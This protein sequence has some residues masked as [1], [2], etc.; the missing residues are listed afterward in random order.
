MTD[1]ETSFGSWAVKY[2]W[3][4]IAVTIFCT[5]SCGAGL[6]HLTFKKDKQVFFGRQNPQLQAFKAFED[7]YTKD[8]NLVIAFAP[9]D[10]NVFSRR[11]LTMLEELT[12][13]CW[14]VPYSSRVYSITNFQNARV[15]GDDLIVEDLFQ[16][17]AGLSDEEIKRR[18]AIALSEPNL[19]NL[20]ISPSGHATGVL[21]TITKPGKSPTETS[22]IADYGRKLVND[23]RSRYPDI[24]FYLTG[25]VM[26]DVALEEATLKDLTT[27][28]PVVCFVLFLCMGVLLRSFTGTIS[29]FLV[30]CASMITAVGL[31]CWFGIEMTPSSSNAPGAILTLAV[32]DSVHILT[33]FFHEMRLGKDKQ[34]AIVEAMRINFQPVYLTSITTTIGF[35]TMNFSDSPPFRDFG[36]TVAMGVMAALVY[37]LLFL[38]ALMAVLPIRIRKEAKTENRYIDRLAEFV[39]KRREP[40]FWFFLI[41]VPIMVYGTFKIELNDDFIKYYDHSFEFRRASDFVGENIT[42]VYRIEYSLDA[43]ESQGINN[44]EYLKTVASFADWYRSQNNVVHVSAVTDIIK[45]LNKNLHD[46][47]ETY[48]RIPDKRDQVAQ[49]LFLYEISLPFGLDL[50]SQINV[51]RSATRMSVNL[52]GATSRTLIEI[53]KKAQQWLATNAPTSMQTFG[54]GTSIIFA[55]ISKRNIKSMLGASF[56][57]LL[58][59][60]VVIMAGMRAYKLIFVFLIPNIIPLIMAFGTWGFIVGRVGLAISVIAALTL[61]IIVDD[62][63][64]YVSKYLRAR[65]E[66]KKSPADAVRYSFHTVGRALFMTTA[67]LVAGFSVLT[68]SH[69]QINSDLGYMTVITLVFALALDFLLLPVLLIKADS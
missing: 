5:I 15:E 37:S 29:A 11:T 9:E 56:F 46:D 40:I 25:S 63:I 42:G 49:L 2:R 16:N 6:R 22:E 67:V 50:N 7:T 66:Y 62:T 65:R 58:F 14:K 52:K 30:I 31:A 57:A 21:V 38:P 20:L 44:P 36:N 4:T 43:G 13:A 28:V 48:Y 68:F 54:V 69:F 23:F 33:T 51:D 32:A 45:R 3:W 64:H 12:E 19:V 60:S 53:D 17:P 34:T 59:I 47:D 61:G 26:I 24:A 18:S 55:H 35:L 10:G 41:L 27:L 1:F 39:V 8:E